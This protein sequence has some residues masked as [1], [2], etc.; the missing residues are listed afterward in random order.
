MINYK[1]IITLVPG[2]I[3][4]FLVGLLG[5][6][7]GNYI[8]YINYLIICI[9]LGLL[10]SNTF[11]LPSFVENGILATHKIWLE[12]GIVILGARVIIKN[13][14]AI[15]SSLLILVLS[16]LLFYI[17]ISYFISL[18]FKLE[19]RLSST[20]ACGL[21]VCGVS[22]AITVGGALQIKAKDLAYIIGVVLLI[23]VITVF[24]WPILGAIFSIPSEVFG[25]WV[26]ISMLSTGTVVAAGFAHSDHAG[27][28]AT[29]IK[30]ARN[31]TIGIWALVFTAY[32]A[33]L[34]ITQNVANKA[35]YFWSKFPKFI[36]GFLFVMLIANIGA[37]SEQQ[38]LSIENAYGWLFMMAFVGLGY[39][40][41][42]KEIRQTGLRPLAAAIISVLLTSI[43][44]LIVLYMLF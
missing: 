34:G 1:R 13:M 5:R 14:A 41:N 15:G 23:D 28:I 32:Y 27:E 8:A 11:R 31:S 30:M 19:P 29:I 20:L 39:D 4:L 2:I 25:P 10:I 3:F 18:K 36:L 43:V 9:L 12:T 6:Y 24:T 44:S 17:C 33:N 35:T 26:G 42:L 40:I 7:I 38:V 21:G 22:A 37:F 16:F